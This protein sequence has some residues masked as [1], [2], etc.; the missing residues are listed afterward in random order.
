MEL[1]PLRT[2]LVVAELGHVTRAARA[3][4]L[5]QPAV[6]AQVAKLEEEIGQA[7]FDRTPKGVVLTAAGTLFRQ[8]VEEGIGRLEAGQRAIRELAG[9]EGGRLSIG[10]GAT[11][12]TYLLPPLLGTFH[13]AHPD[14]RL[15]VREQGSQGVLDAVES[16]EL[17]LGVVT[18]PGTEARKALR[19]IEL[20]RWLDDDLR[21]LVPPAHPLSRRRT[22]RIRDLEGLPFVGFEAGSAVRALLDAYLREAGIAV[23][24]VM[25]LRSIESIKQMVAQGIGSAFVSRYALDEEDHALD[26]KDGNPGRELALA[27]RSDRTP[28]PAAAAFRALL[29]ER[30]AGARI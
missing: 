22:F 6:S 29:R 10:G 16:G 9:L 4:H 5:T 30:A 20:E 1:T 21:L 8:F 23:D 12:T 11:A 28:S 7:L 13:E 15:F 24:V 26:C 3:L 27:T 14:I 19:S 25:E 18:L 2:F 17:D